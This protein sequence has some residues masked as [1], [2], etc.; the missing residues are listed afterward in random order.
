MF[1]DDPV[2]TTRAPGLFTVFV[3]QSHIVHALGREA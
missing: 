2:V 1:T 3:S